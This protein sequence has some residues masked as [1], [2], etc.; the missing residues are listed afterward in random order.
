MITSSD[1]GASPSG[2]AQA[3]DDDLWAGGDRWSEPTT[4]WEQYEARRAERRQSRFD[5]PVPRVGL[6]TLLSFGLALVFLFG[7]AVWNYF[8]G[9]EPVSSI[10]VGDCFIVGEALEIDQVPVVDCE[11]K[12]DSEL[13][14]KVDMAGMGSAYPGDETMFDWLFERCL[15]QFPSYVGEPYETSEYWIDMFIPLEDAWR[16]GDTSGLC[17]LIL[18]DDDLNVRTVA[19]SG[20]N[21]GANA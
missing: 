7:G 3:D 1:S 12:H 9:R 2:P 4:Q 16:E 5:I 18:V 11:R 14:A 13:F 15:E 17:T 21:S 20:R 6:R 19:G 10:A 8:D